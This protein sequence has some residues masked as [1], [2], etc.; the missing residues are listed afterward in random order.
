MTMHT[1]IK[2]TNTIEEFKRLKALM[3]QRAAECYAAHKAAF[4]D[5]QE[6]NIE[7]VWFDESGNICIEYQSGNWWHYNS[8]GEWW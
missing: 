7:K 6:G 8:K 4:E 1:V 5:W 3:E 2:G